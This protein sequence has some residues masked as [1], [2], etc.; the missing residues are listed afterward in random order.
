MCTSSNAFTTCTQEPDYVFV[1]SFSSHVGNSLSVDEMSSTLHQ[2]RTS[3][4]YMSSLNVGTSTLLIER[5]NG[6]LGHVYEFVVDSCEV[7]NKLVEYVKPME[8]LRYLEIGEV[9]ESFNK[10]ELSGSILS[11][12]DAKSH[13]TVGNL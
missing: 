8:N 3:M 4:N 1:V 2:P 7:I 13:V 10:L 9:T 11:Q 6:A 12:A 5:I